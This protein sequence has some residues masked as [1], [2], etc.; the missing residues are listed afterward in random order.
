ML[1]SNS[2]ISY[3]LRFIICNGI[4]LFLVFKKD[5]T[6]FKEQTPALLHKYHAK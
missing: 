4:I 6:R 2:T 3:A 1:Y 5:I